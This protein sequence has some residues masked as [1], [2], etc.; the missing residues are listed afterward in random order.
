[1]VAVSPELF[2]N[3]GDE[4]RDAMRAL[5]MA[6]VRCKLTGPISEERTPL[7]V[8]GSMRFYGIKGIRE[9]IRRWNNGSFKNDQKTQPD[10]RASTPGSGSGG[11]GLTAARL[12]CARGPHRSPQ[13]DGRCQEEPDHR[14]EHECNQQR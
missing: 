10:A 7:L 3:S 11:R 13:H 8:L 9:F 4:D 14:C 1:M 6:G 5:I 2:V 12:P